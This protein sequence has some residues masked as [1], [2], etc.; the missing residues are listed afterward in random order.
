[1]SLTATLGLAV[2]A[3]AAVGEADRQGRPSS[4]RC[5]GRAP[6][7]PPRLRKRGPKERSTSTP[8]RRTHRCDASWTR[9]RS[10][11]VS[12]ATWTRFGTAALQDRFGAEVSAGNP[13]ADLILISNSPWF[14]DAVQ[15]GWII[16]P[17]AAG[18]P[19]WPVEQGSGA[20]PEEVPDEQPLGRR[21][22]AAVGDHVQQESGLGGRRAEELAGPARPEV[23]RQD[24]P[25][26]PDELSG[27]RRSLVGG[28]RRNGGMSYLERLRAQATRLYPGVA[29][30]TQALASGEAA[31]AVPGVPSILQPLVDRGAPLAMN[32]PGRHDRPGGGHRDHEGRPQP[33]RGSALRVLAADAGRAGGAQRRPRLDLAVGREDGP[34]RIHPRRR[35]RLAEAARRD[36]H[37]VR[38]SV[39]R[40][41]LPLW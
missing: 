27:V 20:L 34:R 19:G 5:S 17:G 10:A 37:G 24:H 18:I 15:K 35:E 23:A 25:D 4:R 26:R 11:G 8:S 36:L 38:R 2:G 6:L 40:E 31:I 16:G 28:S 14:G 32:T 13:R 1:M 9:S 41:L 3:T 7:S 21:P 29:P 30:L 22:A 39:A 12:R 33:E